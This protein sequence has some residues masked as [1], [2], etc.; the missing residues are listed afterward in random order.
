MVGVHMPLETVNTFKQENP[1][2]FYS[3]WSMK[4]LQECTQYE[5]VTNRNTFHLIVSEQLQ[6]N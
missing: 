2:K 4:I 1:L 3:N 5:H 6:C